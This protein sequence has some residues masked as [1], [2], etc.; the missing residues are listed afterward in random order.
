[1][2]PVKAEAAPV[3]NNEILSTVAP[4]RWA[5]AVFGV[6]NPGATRRR[7]TDIVRVAVAAIVI[8][9]TAF[10]A[11]NLAETE[12]RIYDLL[13]ELPD[14]TRPVALACYR[15]GAA[16]A[17]IAV[18]A[19]LLVTRRWRVALAGVVSGGVCWLLALE[20]QSWVDSA[21][22]RTE[23]GMNVHGAVPEYPVV[24]LAV[25]TTVLL[26]VAPYLLRP[27]RRLVRASVVISIIGAFVAIVGLPDDVIGGIALGWGVA[28]AFH[29][30]MG[31]PLANPSVAQVTE[32]LAGLGVN[33]GDLALAE[34]Q[35][36]GESRFIAIAPDGARVG[37]QVL[38]R[39]ASDAR[40][41]AKVWRSIWYKDSGPSLALTRE[42][43]LEH[44]AYLALLAAR[45]DVPVEVVVLAGIGGRTENALLVLREPEGQSFATV[46]AEAITDAVLDEAW[47]NVATLHAARIAHGN[48][49]A[50]HLLLQPD[51]R[52]AIVDFAHA[53]PHAPP[54]R[55]ARDGAALLAS[56]AALVGNERALAAAQ[57]SLGNDGLDEVVH[58]LTPVALPPE[59]RKAIPQAKAM[60]AA[61][62]K[63]GAELTGTPEEPV[64]ELR[65]VSPG[66]LAMAAGAMLG[67]YLLIGELAGIDYA[68]VFSTA[69]WGW[70]AVAFL[71]A[72]I[73][74]FATSVALMGAVSMPLPFK[75]VLGEQFANNF[76]G[77]VGGTVANTALVIRFFQKM[78]SSA[79]VAISSGV[80]TSLAAGTVQLCVVVVGLI[81]VGDEFT[82]NRTGGDLSGWIFVAFIAVVL[83]VCA[84]LFVPKVRSRIKNVV[85]PQWRQARDN[86]KGVLSQPRKAAML[87]GGNI[88]AQVLFALVLDASLHAYGESLP[89]LQIMVINSLASV[90]GGMA[91]IPGGMGVVEAGMIAGLTAAGIPQEQAVAATFTH[92]LFTAY[93][94]PVW[95]WFALQWLRRSDYI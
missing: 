64:T 17:A 86:L 45:T 78:G 28:A 92:R 7:P 31:S 66:N 90:L 63:D 60:L 49:T 23:A 58:F 6:V 39:D 38:G 94:P 1:M 70:V 56:T 76:T 46:A 36:W 83:A 19:A 4:R 68:E 32:A 71:L 88:A 20:L 22:V 61:L 2:P 74:Q 26:V 87:F 40:L 81:L 82:P 65:R 37:V 3:A 16:G 93:L 67:V 52:V 57:R 30:A 10:G 75:P 43:Q 73:P 79:V 35:V 11:H 33:V 48:L 29:L 27:A 47:T 34:R 54:E 62:R 21:S 51:G 8:A 53:A 12:K 77:L 91:P 95:G 15:L 24:L 80:L 84:A 5:P 72:P 42:Q 50:Q 89:L 25:A 59:T 18:L 44:R 85:A 69:Q 14:W 41:L 55:V 13:I 9:I